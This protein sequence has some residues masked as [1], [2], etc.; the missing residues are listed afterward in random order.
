[1]HLFHR[2]NIRSDQAMKGST[3]ASFTSRAQRL[4]NQKW[5]HSVGLLSICA[6]LAL[7]GCGGG[8][9]GAAVAT[10]TASGGAIKG[11]LDCRAQGH[12]IATGFGGKISIGA[13]PS[14]GSFAVD[15]KGLTLPVTIT[16]T[17]CMDTITGTTQGFDL[18]T[19]VMGNAKQTTTVNI[20]PIT[21]LIV[22]SAKAAKTGGGAITPTELNAAKATVLNAFGLSTSLPNPLTGVFRTVADVATLV[23]ACEAVSEVIKRSAKATPGGASTANI[24][25]SFAADL[26]DGVLDGAAPAGV[27]IPVP[28]ATANGVNGNLIATVFDEVGTGNLVIH[29][30]DPLTGGVKATLPSSA[31]ANAVAAMASGISGR[32]VGA[33]RI[34]MALTP[35]ATNA[36][37]S[38]KP[39]ITLTGASPMA[40]AQGSV[41]TDPGS[42]VTDNVD[43][44]LVARVTGAVNTAVVGS[45]T[46][47]YNVSDAAGN[48]ATPVT[49][50]V[51]VTDQTG[52]VITLTG[53]NPMTVAQGSV[54]T[55]PG[56][57]VTDN[58]DTGLVATVAGAV[59]TATVRTYTLTYNVSDAAGNAAT[60]LT[61]TVNVTDQ[62]APVI[63][64][65][66]TNLVGV[67]Q[68]ATFTDPGFIAS[69]NVY[70]NISA[71]VTF[72]GALNTNAA[73]G[74][75]FTR[76]YNVSDNAGNAAVQRT[77][78]VMILPPSATALPQIA[79][80][81]AHTVA[82]KSDGTVVAWGGGTTNTGSPPNFGQAMVP[83]GLTGITSIAA[84]WYHTVALKS[85]GSV[86][87]WGGGTTN[88]GKNPEFG[89]AIVPA[90]L[91]G[92][93]AIAAGVYHT[94][95]LKADGT[96]VAWGAGTTNSG[97]FPNYGQAMIPAGLSGVTAIAAGFQHTVAL[98]SNGTV[99][100]WGDNTLGQTT[101]PAGLTNV[102][103]ISAG[104]YHTVVL[105]A[106]G[107]VV[108]WGANRFGQINVPTGLTGVISIAAGHYHTAALKSDGTVVVWGDN[109]QNQTTIPAGLT[110][111]IAIA[112]GSYHTIAL[113]SDGTLVAWG[114]NSSGQ[115]TFPTGLNLMDVTAP[116]ITLTGGNIT[117]A[118][119]TTFTDPG[120]S[121]N[122]D[123]DG[124]ITANVAVS[125]GPV[126]TSLSGTYTLTYNV[127]DK[128]GNAATPVTRSVYVPDKIAPV[129]TL[130]GTNL[131]G[132][133]QGATFT[134]P[135][136]TASDNVDGN[137]TANVVTGGTVNTGAAVGT[138]FTRTYNVS[139]TAG[140]AAVQKT[141][142]VMILSASAT[143]MPQVA[144]GKYHTVALKSD[145]TL[146][147]W[148]NN[149]YGQTTI[150]I[151]L[152][153]ITA[154]AVGDFH[155][156]ALKSNGTVVAWGSNSSGQTN[157]PAGLTGVIAI[158]AGQ[159]HTVAL[160]SD[161]TVVAWGAGTTNTGTTVNYGQSVPPLGL[162]GVTAIG[163]EYYQTVALKSDGTVVAWG[164]NGLLGQTTI[165]AG[166]SGITAIAAG[167]VHTVALKSNGTVVAWGDNTNGEIN[168][169]AGLAGVIAIAAGLHH[170]VALK[171]DGTV[172]A[173]GLNT[174]L[175]ISV[176]L[177][178]T[179]VIAIAAGV[180]YTVALKSD[181][182][183]VAWGFNNQG[184][185][186]IPTGLNLVDLTP[187]VITLSGGNIT[188]AQGGTFTDPGYS[189][190]DNLDGNIT[191]NV[192]TSG[193]PVNTGSVGTYT[194]TYNI[195]DAAGNAA[196]PV[197][198]TVQITDQ[199]AP[200]ITLT[201]ANPL[202]VLQGSTF[203]DP[204]STVTDNVDTGLTATV[205]G[206]VN[207]ASVGTYTLTY[208]ISDAA[209]NAATT[210]TRTVNVM[211]T[212]LP[213]LSIAPAK[214]L[215]GSTLGTTNLVFT[216]TLSA[217]SASS[218]T[219]NY[220]TSDGTALA[221]SDYTAANASLTI[222]AGATTG[223]ITLLVNADTL[224]EPDETL[225]LTLSVPTGATLGTAVATGTI[226]NDDAGLNDT[227][228]GQ[229]GNAYANS[230]FSTQAQFPV[231]DADVG[232][233]A[234][235]AAGTLTKKG[236]GKAGFD[237]T[238]LDA[239]GQPLANQAATPWSCVQDN[240]TGLMWEVKTTTVGLRK[241]S[242]TYSWFNSNAATNGGGAGKASGGTCVDG[243]AGLSCD[244]EK[245][246][247]AVNAVG[248]CGFKD[249]RLPKKEE[250]R[251]IVHYGVYSFSPTSI[252][253]AYFPNTVSQLR[254]FW[255]WTVTPHTTNNAYAIGVEFSEG[256]DGA[257]LKSAPAYVR[258]V[259]G[260]P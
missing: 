12:V 180:N 204:G 148:G 1:M 181:G 238:K 234:L 129:I 15:M 121:A 21:T 246:V 105:K 200:V 190:I 191:A 249:W 57:T 101:I 143:T 125:G 184:Q 132:V 20:T 240:V 24:M 178:L 160:K 25:A 127:T 145:G 10:G 69:D 112:A 58:V 72:G 213:T 80:G 147:A 206:T 161:G 219:V 174:S 47:T 66:G 137:I 199:T 8:G 97:A 135:G 233:D 151:G 115:T 93:T 175:Q 14:V 95:A 111:I 34:N 45:Y 152:T 236:G 120:Y 41:F 207:T 251:S 32:G 126:N 211:T 35:I 228:M 244:T 203:T 79:A 96:V 88:T 6:A 222:T 179:G 154:I 38:S 65:K 4:W 106:D 260:R 138:I 99:V 194:L 117:V 241:S 254:S 33:G 40:V 216:V 155:T 52:P 146:A 44:G 259:R 16:V 89:Q 225:T 84:G 210:V 131:V 103:A 36:R 163:A 153:G 217:A 50:T 224:F 116:V 198:R 43:T 231:Q 59:N 187:P 5:K 28:V 141:R 230:F 192:V 63:G 130:K 51:N 48:A 67:A 150:P 134:D 169:P 248:L 124:N 82:L 109:T 98:K 256:A 229:W 54:F 29:D 157:V 76:T 86:M 122:D 167:G 114:A 168:I 139:D 68:G 166:L 75:I 110:G 26:A 193:G 252:D 108:A 19:M 73:I 70:G 61:R 242:H 118:Q 232:R 113:K 37:I 49:R 258:L 202:S 53:A 158:A 92:I 30:V 201:G 85:N 149:V 239:L 128:A 170:T 3:G 60:Q 196:T 83:A 2:N 218:V 31:F 18:S 78:R 123:V 133:A 208:N 7:S 221:A 9:G 243:I 197:T 188:V 177:G 27:P 107:T 220:A 104:G 156:V 253:T 81:S 71:K 17:G 119:G 237:F 144:A 94:V 212:L 22:A 165:P 159:A 185:T 250:L 46:L 171:S 186:A 102:I 142:R 55:D 87:A 90:G 162:A 64:L 255:Y 223:T 227:G 140:N 91:T 56:S 23:A 235:A 176:P 136:F 62:T 245:Y 215:E 39:V 164:W 42:T 247:A 205:T 183:V 209:G 182:T 214:V 74:T 13:T 189:A 195:S 77:R 100:A 257:H 172:V 226:L 11:P 173:W